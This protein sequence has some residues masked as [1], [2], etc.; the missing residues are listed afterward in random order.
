MSS[1]YFPEHNHPKKKKKK[2]QEDIQKRIEQLMN[3]VKDNHKNNPALIVSILDKRILMDS[4][5][6]N[7]TLVPSLQIDVTHSLKQVKNFANKV[8]NEEVSHGN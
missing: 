7:N 6:Q 4:Y 1:I 8:R 5:Y 3:L 2:N